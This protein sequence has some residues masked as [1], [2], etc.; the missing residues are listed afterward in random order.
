LTYQD[1]QLKLLAL[2]RDRIHNGDLTERSLARRI[3]VS[4]PHVHNVLKG[5]RNLSPEIFDSMLEHFQISLLDLAPAEDLE[6][7]LRRRVLERSAEV[8]LLPGAIGPGM[9]WPPVAEQR[10]RFP[11]PFPSVAAP[12]ELIMAQLSFDP[13]MSRT[14]AGADI[15]LLDVSEQR[16]RDFVP[17]G[18]YVIRRGGEALL[19]YIR[20]GSRC[21]YLVSDTNLNHPAAWEE[22]RLPLAGMEEAVAARVRWLGR[23]SDRNLP[24][25][26]RGGFL[27][28]PIS[29]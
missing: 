7:S 10:R 14:L 24:L 17:D 25:A 13:D 11:L 16:R 1:A 21:Y 15:A 18:L 2:V 8:G 5:V 28:D 20:P 9:P 4:Q 26:Q 19:R 3:G 29:R 27:Y 12:P 22:L 6:T 23:E